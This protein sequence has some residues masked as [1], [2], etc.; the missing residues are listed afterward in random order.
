[1]ETPLLQ[2][3]R[4]AIQFYYEEGIDRVLKCF[5]EMSENYYTPASP[6]IFNAGTKVPQ[7]SSCFLVSIDDTLKSIL[8]DG[9][10]DAGTISS[11]SGGLGM[12]LTGVRHSQIGYTGMSSGIL[13]ISRIYDRTIEYSNQR[14]KR[15]GAGTLF[16][17]IWHI[18]IWDFIKSTDMFISHEQRLSAEPARHFPMRQFSHGAACSNSFSTVSA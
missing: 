13:P 10:G 9:V 3:M 16:L 1:M 6:T 2:N 17:A 5:N 14:G 8:Y 12:G 15:K 7:M 11:L 18:D 4:I